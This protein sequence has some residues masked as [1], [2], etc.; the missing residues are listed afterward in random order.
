MQ[1]F[2]FPQLEEFGSLRVTFCERRLCPTPPSPAQVLCPNHPVA[3]KLFGKTRLIRQRVVGEH[4]VV[5]GAGAVGVLTS[6]RVLL[7]GH[8]Q[9]QVLLS[10]ERSKVTH[11]S[12]ISSQGYTITWLPEY[13]T[14]LF[15]CLSNCCCASVN[16]R[17]SCLTLIKVQPKVK[18]WATF[19]VICERQLWPTSVDVIDKTRSRSSTSCLKV[20]LCDGTGFQHSL[21]IMYLK[22]KPEGLVMPHPWGFHEMFSN[23]LDGMF[24]VIRNHSLIFQPESLRSVIKIKPNYRPHPFETATEANCGM[25]QA[26]EWAEKPHSSLTESRQDTETPT[27]HGCSW[28]VCPSGVPPSAAWRVLPRGFLDMANLPEW[29]FPTTTLRKTTCT[30]RETQLKFCF[31]GQQQQQQKGFL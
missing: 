22:N 8:R 14:T 28:Q 12:Q 19:S 11:H 3:R 5:R 6:G 10:E 16:Y 31:G 7:E 13:H 4:G 26:H 25:W 20:G 24:A 27:V 9:V 18:L 15:P 23:V 29:R 30:H 1:S 2:S 17:P 21:M